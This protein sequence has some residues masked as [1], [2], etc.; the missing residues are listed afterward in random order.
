MIC[1]IFHKTVDK[2]NAHYPEGQSYKINEIYNLSEDTK[3]IAN[4]SSPALFL[5]N[6]DLL[7]PARD[8]AAPA[9]KQCCKAE[10]A[11]NCSSSVVF[12]QL[13]QLPDLAPTDF[14]TEEFLQN[15]NLLIFEMGCC[16][17]G[18]NPSGTDLQLQGMAAFNSSS[19][20]SSSSSSAITRALIGSSW[21]LLDP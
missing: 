10:A 7:I 3:L 9:P 1:R 12:P 16:H 14:H 11:D 17:D 18:M 8:R 5:P 6:R 13:L 15:P 21:P 19:L 2:K 20:S 4:P